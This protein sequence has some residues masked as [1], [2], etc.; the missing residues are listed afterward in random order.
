MNHAVPTK[1]FASF[2]PSPDDARTDKP[3]IAWF[4]C[5]TLLTLLGLPMVAYGLQQT[6]ADQIPHVN[7]K[8][9]E[10]F[11]QYIYADGHK[12]FAIAP[13]GTWAWTESE[14]SKDEAETNAL[15]RC[16]RQTE[17]SCV[18]YSLNDE[19]VFD[20]DTWSS[21]WRNKPDQ[22][23]KKST[24]IS[25]GAQFPNLRFKD[26]N[27]KSL[28]LR[29][30]TGKVT[31]VH[32]WASWCPP[33]MREMPVLLKMQTALQQKH[34]NKVAI[35]LLQVRE[36]FSS[37]QKWAKKYKFDSLPLYDSGVINIDDAAL[38]T[39]DGK[40]YPDRQL[41]KAFPTSYVLDRYGKVLFS[42]NGPIADWFEYLP[43]FTDVVNHSTQ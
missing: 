8:A 28:S 21:L 25:R 23:K 33:C 13:G 2:Y 34:G 15:Q 41:A 10:S 3:S 27:G 4:V 19:I 40:T 43:F 9:R 17:Q 32:F 42:H 14:A 16:Q 7:Q 31:L 6:Q 12:A 36:S 5:A 1:S 22:T 37:S 35:V 24:G 39:V 29:D 20:S 30:F 26:R 11:V 38:K 18:L